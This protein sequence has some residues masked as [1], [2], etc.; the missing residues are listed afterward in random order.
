MKYYSHLNSCIKIID[1]YSGKEPFHLF[2]K[3]FFSEHKKYG[4]GDRKN[5]ASL[6][7]SYF[8][9]GKSLP[10]ASIEQK[11]IAGLFLC[12]PAANAVLEFLHPSLNHELRANNSLEARLKHIKTIHP[13]FNAANIFS[14]GEE[15][16]ENID[17]NAF[18]ASHL[19]Q[20][21]LFARIR[22]GHRLSVLN[23]LDAAQ[24]TYEENGD[25]L[26][27]P[28]GARI[29]EII[30]I[31]REAVIQDL[32]SQRTAE[33]CPY[34][35]KHEQ[36]IKIWDCCAASGGKSIMAIDY[37]EP[38]ELTVSDNRESILSNLSQRFQK[39]GIRKYKSVTTDLSIQNPTIP[40]GQF[41]LVIADV[42]CSGSGTWGR[43]P[44][45]LLYFEEESVARYASL[46]K[47]IVSAI[48]SSIKPNGYL[49]YITCSVFKKEN[50]EMVEWI[51]AQF[52]LQLL[53]KELITGYDL[54]ADTMFAAV[55][56]KD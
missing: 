51:S 33:L 35:N 54:K 40:P 41:D 23:K 52:P 13:D 39:A 42:P 26:R 19:I 7:Y 31:D 22:P 21:D 2:V 36:P 10:S 50:S 49:L 3:R 11:I 5:I 25:A 53:K 56:K 29:G 24:I 47:K 14:F 8:R 15:L 37:L 9:L 30:D 45:Q 44:E 28:N 34:R 6:C 43:T 46:Q 12:A 55:F 18:S 4:S 17:A 27:L 20:P 48:A 16:E 32:S 1:S 38:I